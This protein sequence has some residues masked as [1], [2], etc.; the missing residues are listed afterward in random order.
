MYIYKNPSEVKYQALLKTCGPNPCDSCD[1]KEHCCGECKTQK[2][3]LK[4]VSSIHFDEWWEYDVCEVPLNLDIVTGCPTARKLLLH[5]EIKKENIGWKPIFDVINS[6]KRKHHS[7]G[8]YDHCLTIN[9]YPSD[10]KYWLSNFISKEVD[11]WQEIDVT[12][13]EREV[14]EAVR[15]ARMPVHQMKLYRR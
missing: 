4:R 9:I 1:E 5:L 12:V 13:V 8:P 11:L 14:M 15:A 7:K 10:T 2:K 3:W 6:R